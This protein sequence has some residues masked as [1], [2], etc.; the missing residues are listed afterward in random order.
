MFATTRMLIARRSLC[1]T[2]PSSISAA[3][4]STSAPAAAPTSLDYVKPSAV[5]VKASYRFGLTEA[6]VSDVPP[7]VRPMLS[8]ETASQQEINA[9]QIKAAIEKFQRFPGDTGSSEVQIAVLTQKI[10]RLTA[11]LKMHRKDNHTTR[12]LVALVTKRRNLIKYLKRTDFQ[13][14]K[15]VVAALGLRFK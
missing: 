10:T 4:K 14:F 1:S 3:F 15:A 9:A 5:D 13:K 11:H 6:Q 7:H 2:K 12:G 8:L